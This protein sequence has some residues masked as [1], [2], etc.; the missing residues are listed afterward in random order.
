MQDALTAY[1][2]DFHIHPKVKKLFEQRAE[3]GTGTRL[4]DYGMAE[5]VAF[6]SLLEDGTPVRLT[7]QDSQRGTFNQRHSVMVDTETEVRYS[8][9]AHRPQNAGH[10]SRSTTLCSLRP[11]CSASSTATRATIP[12]RW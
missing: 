2:A 3:M 4:F 6:A 10:A 11:Q 9:L 12:R 8:P 1:P 5:L 7:G